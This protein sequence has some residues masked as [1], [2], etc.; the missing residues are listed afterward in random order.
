MKPLLKEFGPAMREHELSPDETEYTLSCEG[1]HST[2]ENRD[3][4]D[5]VASIGACRR[6]RQTLCERFR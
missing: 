5:V 1:V 6:R 4:E 3:S 2:T